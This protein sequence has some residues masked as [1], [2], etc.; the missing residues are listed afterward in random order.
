MRTLFQNQ[1]DALSRSNA[2]M[3]D[4]AGAAMQ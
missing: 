1:V 3:W 4:L 2:D